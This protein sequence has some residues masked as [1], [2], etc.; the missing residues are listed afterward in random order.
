MSFMI[1]ETS[2]P[3]NS[4]GKRNS[5]LILINCLNLT[6]N[7]WKYRDAKEEN[8]MLNYTT[9]MLTETK[10]P[11]KHISWS[12]QGK[13]KLCKKREREIKIKKLNLMD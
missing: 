12:P 8:N 11:V 13:K 10:N 2:S 5:G 9:W 1:K 3:V 4:L 7:S 6:M